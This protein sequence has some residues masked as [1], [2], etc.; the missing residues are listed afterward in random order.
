MA[1]LIS[2]ESLMENDK[3]SIALYSESARV[4]SDGKRK[5]RRMSSLNSFIS[6]IRRFRE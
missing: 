3:I 1:T 5:V 4:I 2:G 6:D